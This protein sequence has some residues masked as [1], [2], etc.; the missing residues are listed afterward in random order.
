MP[1]WLPEGDV[2]LPSDS[3]LRSMEKYVSL[4]LAANGNKASPYPE[5]CVP[6]PG[7][8]VQRLSAKAVILR[9]A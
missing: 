6:L 1:S 5:G 8:D 2:S 4:L 3:E 7:D 9:G